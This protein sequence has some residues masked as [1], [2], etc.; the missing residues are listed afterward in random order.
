MF[1]KNIFRERDRPSLAAKIVISA[2]YA[3]AESKPA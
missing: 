1:V 2:F 3:I